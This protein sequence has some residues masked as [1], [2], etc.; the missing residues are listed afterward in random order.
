MRKVSKD[1]L[2]HNGFQ[3]IDLDLINLDDDDL[4]KKSGKKITLTF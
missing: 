4:E 1:A 2:K 3:R